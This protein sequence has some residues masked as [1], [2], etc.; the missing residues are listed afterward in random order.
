MINKNRNRCAPTF[1][2]INLLGECN[3]NCYFCLGK[4]ILA[5]LNG[6]NQLDIH[7]LQ[8]KNF[9][10]F[11]NLCKKNNIK[12]LYF[13]GQTSD[14]LQYN[15]LEEAVDYLQ[16]LGF[17]VGVRTNG[18]LAEEKIP[19]IQKMKGEIGYSIHSLKDDTNFQIMGSYIKPN[20]NRIIPLSGDNVR[21]LIVLCRYNINEFFD[22][23]E[24]ISQFKN[25]RYIQV[26]RIST[27]TRYDELK[28]DA[29]LYEEFHNEIEKEYPLIGSFYAAQQYEISGKEVNFWRTV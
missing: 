28:E 24:Y 12:K 18:F 21:G 1:A 27:D 7:F 4:D 19:I 26:R 25:V 8:W 10:K 22:L 23:V 3:A 17:E 16:F 20:W 6:K 2:N 15:F 13:T 14:G 5:Q 29:E 11:L 9:N